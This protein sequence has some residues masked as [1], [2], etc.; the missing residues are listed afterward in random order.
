MRKKMLVCALALSM[1]MCGCSCGDSADKNDDREAESES[2]RVSEISTELEESVEFKDE[3]QESVYVVDSDGNKL[4]D[5]E[6]DNSTVTNDSREVVSSG[7]NTITLNSNKIEYAGSGAK[8]SGS[9]IT[10]TSGGEYVITGTINDGRIVVDAG[11]KD[12]VKLILAGANI[13]SKNSAGIYIKNADKTYIILADNTTNVINDGESYDYDDVTEEEPNGAVFSKDDLVISGNGRLTVNGNFN[14]G[15]VSKDDLKI[16]GGTIVVNAK[17]NGI[18][19]KDSIA[20]SSGNITVNAGGDGLKADNDTDADKG[21]I[22]ILDGVF[23]ITSGEDGIQAEKNIEI[24][25]GTFTIKTG[26]GSSTSLSSGTT[27][28]KGIKTAGSISINGG[29][30]DI[31]SKDDCIH[32]NTDVNLNNGTFTLSSGDDGVHADTNLTINDGT[33]TIKK[34]YEGLEATYIYICGGTINVTA[35]DDGINAAGGND[36]S[37]M[38]GRPGMGGF[39]EGTGEIEITGGN[40][41]VNAGGDGIDSNGNVVFKA[42]TAIVYGP[43]NSGNGSLDYNGTWTQTGGELIAAGSS[44]MAQMPGTSSTQNSVMITFTSAYGSGDVI[45]LKDSSGNKVAEFTGEKSFNNIVFCNGNLKTGE[46]Y[47]IYVNG[48]EYDSFTISSVCTTVGNGG[49]MQGGHDGMQGGRP[50]FR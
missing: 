11:D 33:Y 28:I 32:S 26:G 27:S 24:T 34:S 39:S 8:I 19:G 15:I 1:I 25:K 29:S 10:I 38:G 49:G 18:K 7:N 20:V 30:F 4:S 16:T 43:T 9:E 40:I 44:G 42:G 23:N 17:N 3:E 5:N 46:T 22:Y 2:K 14:N 13:T 35:S 6:G 45:T 12:E 41:I 36:S 37:A 50:G 21:Y 47:K 48:T 31:D